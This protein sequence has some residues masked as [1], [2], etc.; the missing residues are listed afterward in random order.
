VSLLT[1]LLMS[2]VASASPAQ[3]CIDGNAD[4]CRQLALAMNSSRVLFEEGCLA[5]DVDSCILAAHATNPQEQDTGTL[6]R[7]LVAYEACVQAPAD[8]ESCRTELSR[9][10]RLGLAVGAVA[11]ELLEPLC[12]SGDAPACEALA[13]VQ[14]QVLHVSSQSSFLGE[15]SPCTQ[16]PPAR[17]RCLRQQVEAAVATRSTVMAAAGFPRLAVDPELHVRLESPVDLPQLQAGLSAIGVHATSARITWPGGG[18]SVVGLPRL[19]HLHDNRRPPD[20]EG[21]EGSEPLSPEA[22]KKLGFGRLPRDE[23]ERGMQAVLP[24]VQGCY[25]Q[26]LNDNPQLGGRVEVKFVIAR[27]GSVSS[28]SAVSSELP[29]Q[30]TKCILLEVKRATF[31]KPADNGLVVVRYPFVFNI[32]P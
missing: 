11:Q 1:L 25:Q 26:A 19:F 24:G 27:T 7:H 2:T 8:P 16:P 9:I 23:I 10:S 3:A 5:G 14:P 29:E 15:Q 6:W 13:A 17:H 31:Q 18:E 22:L 28:A 4:A 30:V 20:S 32:S 21:S 12:E